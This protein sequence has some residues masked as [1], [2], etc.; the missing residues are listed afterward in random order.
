MQKQALPAPPPEGVGLEAFNGWA[1]RQQ[2]SH[3]A[4]SRPIQG[5]IDLLSVRVSHYS[6]QGKRQDAWHSVKLRHEFIILKEM[7]KGSLKASSKCRL[8]DESTYSHRPGHSGQ[9]T[10]V[11]WKLDVEW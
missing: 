3:M 2:V 7:C 1:P 4:R 9:N 11:F 6:H 8:S 10:Q 5:P